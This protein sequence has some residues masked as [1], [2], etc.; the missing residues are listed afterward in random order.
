MEKEFQEYTVFNVTAR[1][2]SDVEL[3]VVDEFEFDKKHYVAAAV[4]KNEEIDDSG[5]YIYRIKMDS[6]D[7][8]VEEITDAKE[9]EDVVKAYQE[10]ED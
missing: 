9:Y 5:R 7:F 8:E 6:E 3:A 10:M 2:G 1:D 4:V